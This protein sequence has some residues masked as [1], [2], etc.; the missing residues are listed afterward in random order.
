MR[1][2]RFYVLSSILLIYAMVHGHASAGLPPHPTKS[3]DVMFVDDVNQGKLYPGQ[4]IGNSHRFLIYQNDGN[5]VFYVKDR[6]GVNRAKW[7]TDTNQSFCLGYAEVSAIYG[8]AVY[9][10]NGTRRYNL[11]NTPQEHTNFH[12]VMEFS[13]LRLY[14][15]ETSK[16]VWR[17]GGESNC[18]VSCTGFVDFDMSSSSVEDVLAAQGW[19]HAN[20]IREGYSH[21]QFQRI[22][23]DASH[24]QVHR[25]FIGMKKH[26]ESADVKIGQVLDETEKSIAIYARNCVLD[27]IEFCDDSA[28]S[29]PGKI[30]AQYEEAKVA[31][32]YLE[33][34]GSL[35]EAIDSGALDPVDIF[36]TLMPTISPNGG[37]D[38]EFYEAVAGFLSDVNDDDSASPATRSLATNGGDADIWWRGN[39]AKGLGRQAGRT[40]FDLAPFETSISFSEIAKITNAVPLS[41]PTAALFNNIQARVYFTFPSYDPVRNESK[42]QFRVKVADLAGATLAGP[43]AGVLSRYKLEFDTGLFA[44]HEWVWTYVHRLDNLST[45]LEKVQ[46][47]SSLGVL[48]EG[49]FSFGSLL[50]S[51]GKKSY[52]SIA[53]LAS[54]ADE[55]IKTP[56]DVSHTDVVQAVD[57]NAQN[58]QFGLAQ[59]DLGELLGSYESLSPE[60]QGLVDSLMVN[61]SATVTGFNDVLGDVQ[62]VS[63]RINEVLQ[64]FGFEPSFGGFRYQPSKMLAETR[65]IDDLT[66][67]EI[68]SLVNSMENDATTHETV[69]DLLQ[70]GVSNP[71]Q[72]TGQFE[73]IGNPDTITV[74]ESSTTRLLGALKSLG[75]ILAGQLETGLSC[76]IATVYEFSEMT[77]KEKNI[78]Y[79]SELAATGMFA[80][81]AGIV[82]SI[83]VP[84]ADVT[85]GNASAELGGYVMGDSIAKLFISGKHRTGWDCG[86][87]GAYRAEQL[88]IGT[89]WLPDGLGEDGINLGLAQRIRLQISHT[90]WGSMAATNALNTTRAFHLS[91]GGVTGNWKEYNIPWGNTDLAKLD[92]MQTYYGPDTANIRVREKDSR[93]YEVF[94]EEETS[95]DSETRHWAQETIGVMAMGTGDIIDI[96]G[97][98]IGEAGRIT[99]NANSV[100]DYRTLT[101]S[102]NY[103]NPVVVMAVNTYAGS[104]PIHVR[105]AQLTAT[106][107]EYQQEEWNYRDGYH[108]TET[109]SY[110]VLEA[111]A[112]LI[113]DGKMIVAG[114]SMFNTREFTTIDIEQHAGNSLF[115]AGKA[116][117][118]FA[119]PH[120]GQSDTLPIVARLQNVNSDSFALKLQREEKLSA[121]NHRTEEVGFIVLGSYDFGS[122]GLASEFVNFND[123]TI[124]S[125]GNNQDFPGT[126]TVTVGGNGGSLSINGNQWKSINFNYKVTPNTV[127]EFT[128]QSTLSPEISG[129]G[130]D[131][132]NGISKSKFFQVYGNQNW[133]IRDYTYNVNGPQRFSIPVGTYFTGDFNRLVFANDHDAKTPWGNSTYTDIFLYEK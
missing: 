17:V 107:V 64:V 19:E 42:F 105:L 13:S 4:K 117:L 122:G 3:N 54:K 67:A 104:D 36:N 92:F 113:S 112:Y 70:T 5:L 57:E 110:V 46:Y 41:L 32:E 121:K 23:N 60:A 9:D 59:S 76:S 102:N 101:F 95:A 89:S 81:T 25:F 8:I 85:I 47:V 91:V 72:G 7:S 74:P 90:I 27:L 45:S 77:A 133:A 78:L 2:L 55:E 63:I 103:S 34:L 127:M 83:Y 97:E 109:I 118:V 86:V 132:D 62:P 71:T 33:T 96:S 26:L 108:V 38:L 128:F 68:N 120:Q 119:Q 48:A 24:A 129:I 131:V 79:A 30:L 75:M 115:E 10:C 93:N 61:D 73:V 88:A 100:N 11:Y 18:G 28:V 114:K 125:Y 82:A 21:S 87:W 43:A 35:H 39:V 98:V 1:C 29:S 126:G 69:S 16:M 51:I 6:Q 14:N 80:T 12:L 22:F 84:E 116:P 44:G 130:F 50:R 66:E 124:S 94:V 106:S 111:G 53:A 58:Y 20:A 123:Y 52:S 99:F 31:I 49:T 40:R 56:S 15:M 37:T 65:Q